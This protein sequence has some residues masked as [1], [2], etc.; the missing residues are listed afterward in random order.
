MS[1]AAARDGLRMR[2]AALGLVL[3]ASQES[4]ALDAVAQQIAL[5]DLAGQRRDPPPLLP[6]P[7]YAAAPS[8]RLTRPWGWTAAG[9][10]QTQARLAC[11]ATIFP[12]SDDPEALPVA[13]K[14]VFRFDAHLPNAGLPQPPEAMVLRPS[15]VIARLGTAGAQVVATTRLSPWC[16]LPVEWS[17]GAPPPRHPQA[18][19][20]LVGGSSSGS[21]V[22]VSAS[23]VPVALGTDTGG[24]VRIPAALCGIY[25]FKPTQGRIP[26][27]GT[28][29]LGPSQD[30]I[31]LM[32][33]EP[34][35]LRQ[36]FDAIALPPAIAARAARRIAIP[37]GIFV[38][39]EPAIHQAAALLGTRLRHLGCDLGAA[40]ALA[41]GRMNALAGLLTGFEAAQ[42]HGPRMARFPAE[43]PASVTQRLQLGLAVPEAIYHQARWVQIALSQDDALFGGADVLM[44]PVVNRASYPALEEQS[45]PPAALSQLCLGLLSL[46]RWVNLLGLPALSIPVKPETGQAAAIQLIGRHGQDE[47]LLELAEDLRLL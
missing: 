8:R 47:A 46:N 24:S 13:V 15:P 1:D 10:A 4:L 25:G 18:P 32:A 27:L 14:D 9:L 38:Q 31:G 22:A 3:T 11:F 30:C 40:P 29:P 34:E 43:Y 26:T 6:E 12:A 42:L 45:C 16:Y 7:G 19:G 37:D 44:T 20:L 28:V 2:V 39:S 33:Q 17:D 35:L 36:V 21:A 5:A 23:A 41:L